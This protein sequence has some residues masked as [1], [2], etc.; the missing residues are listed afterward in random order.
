MRK[1]R[2]ALALAR[3][4]EEHLVKKQMNVRQGMQLIARESYKDIGELTSGT[5]SQADLNR[6]GNPYGR[7]ARNPSGKSRGRRQN[8]LLNRQSSRL[9]DAAFLDTTGVSSS[10]ISFRVG[11]RPSQPYFKYVLARGGTIKMRDRGIWAEIEKRFKARKLGLRQ[12]LR[13]GN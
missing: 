12:A 6:A 7:G 2:S 3:S 9:H 8:A 1:H 10:K 5:E 11:I 13:R 4:I